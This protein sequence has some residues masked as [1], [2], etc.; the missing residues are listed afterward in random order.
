MSFNLYIYLDQPFQSISF[1][2]SLNMWEG[3]KKKQ[4]KNKLGGMYYSCMSMRTDIISFGESRK[5]FLC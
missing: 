1:T 3:Q 5:P 2:W 4:N